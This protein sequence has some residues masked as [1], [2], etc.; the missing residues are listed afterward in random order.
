M[1]TL[2]LSEEHF[3]T[4]REAL[5]DSLYGKHMAVQLLAKRFGPE[6]DLAKAEQA[7][8]DRLAAAE[9]AFLEDPG[10]WRRTKSLPSS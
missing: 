8:Y 4:I 7:D 6:S 9:R 1:K 3:E 5:S 2:R 10:A